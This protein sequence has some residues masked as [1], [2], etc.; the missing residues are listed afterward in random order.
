MNHETPSE[1]TN[2]NE[3]TN[4][5]GPS[6]IGSPQRGDHLRVRYRFYHHH[7]IEMG[8]GTVIHFGR[9]LSDIANARV[10]IV[11]RD[12]F[13]AGREIQVVN[14][15]SDFSADQ[16]IDRAISRVDETNYNLFNN[17]C[18]HFV[19]WCRHDRAES[20]QISQT[21]S[22]ARFAAAAISKPV[23]T[24]VFSR[25]LGKQ[26]ARQAATRCGAAALAG[27][28]SQAAVEM[29]AT[30]R[31][32]NRESARKIGLQAGAATAATTGLAVGGPVGSAAGLVMWAA[33]Q[34]IAGRTVDRT[35]QF[36]NDSIHRL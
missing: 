21:E 4:D 31:G 30:K 34:V 35:K 14:S 20:R 25:Q 11:T 7:G 28:A 6:V 17:N 12:E 9:G 32:V 27:D 23:V 16:I 18:E 3:P 2:R 5:A 29:Y 8:D 24:R 36:A 15:P 22:L 26:M 13:A 1:Q 33:G 19:N 10:E